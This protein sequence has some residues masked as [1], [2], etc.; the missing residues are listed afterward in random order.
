MS[1]K[2]K[3][4]P[5]GVKNGK[6]LIQWGKCLKRGI[7]FKIFPQRNFNQRIIFFMSCSYLFLLLLHSL[8]KA[9]FARQFQM[10]YKHILWTRAV[11]LIDAGD[12]AA[13]DNPS[14]VSIHFPIAVGSKISFFF[15]ANPGL[16]IQLISKTKECLC[17]HSLYFLGGQKSLSR[18]HLRK[19]SSLHSSLNSYF[20]LSSGW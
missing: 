6:H 8:L 1:L 14:Q 18:P 2:K 12:P 17:F 10:Y 7:F 4:K 13:N 15:K 19:P 9:S 16:R 20:C 11:I 3:K 5:R